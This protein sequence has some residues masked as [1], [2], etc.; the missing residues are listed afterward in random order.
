MVAPPDPPLPLEEWRRRIDRL[1]ARL[2]R[3]LNERAACAQAIAREKRRRGLEVPDPAREAQVLERVC[4]LNEGPLSDGALERIFRAVIAEMRAL[5][6][7]HTPR[8]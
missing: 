1:D 4:R 3:L 7:R 6:G 5:E 8:P 2:V